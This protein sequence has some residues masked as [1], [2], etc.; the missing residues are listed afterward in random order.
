MP[1]NLSLSISEDDSEY[2]LIWTG[3]FKLR[4][5]C[6]IDFSALPLNYIFHYCTHSWNRTND[7]VMDLKEIHF[8]KKGCATYISTTLLHAKLCGWMDWTYGWIWTTA[9]VNQ[10]GWIY[11]RLL[12]GSGLIFF[13][14]SDALPTELHKSFVFF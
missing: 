4:I 8:Y 3:I 11:C 2:I 9:Y 5:W 13:P 7:L 6:S 14:S 12:S 1:D 10:P